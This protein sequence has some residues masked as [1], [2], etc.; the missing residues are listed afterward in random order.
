MIEPQY[1]VAINMRTADGYVETGTFLLSGS[2]EKALDVFGQLQGE[3]LVER[4]LLRMDLIEREEYKLDTVIATLSC[5]LSEM[6]ANVKIV[7]KE[8]FRLLNLEE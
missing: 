3:R 2:K 7:M 4:P 8:T 6:L 5:S 1:L